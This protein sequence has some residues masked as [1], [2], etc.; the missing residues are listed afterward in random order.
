MGRVPRRPNLLGD[1]QCVEDD[2]SYAHMYC[3]DR[4]LSFGVRWSHE[5]AVVQVM[6]E[7]FHSIVVKY[8]LQSVSSSVEQGRAR[9]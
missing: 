7:V 8:I 9:T 2:Q 6:H 1:I 5:K 3:R 4:L